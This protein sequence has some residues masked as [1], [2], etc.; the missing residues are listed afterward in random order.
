MAVLAQGGMVVVADEHDR[1]NEADLIMA[2]SA[3]TV[4]QMTFFLRHGSGIVCTPMADR[5]ADEL[6]LP[7]MVAAST[8]NHGTAFTVT[9]DHIGTGT[10]ISAADRVRTVRALADPATSPAELRRPGHIFPL[11]ARPGGVLKRAG[12]TEAAVDLLA[13]AGAGEVAVI[14]ELV[15]DDGVPMAGV[16]AREFAERHGLTFVHVDDLVRERR[17]NAGLIA[18]TGRAQLP[19]GGNRFV[20]TTYRSAADGI[21]HIALTLGDLAVAD[22]D[23]RGA[24]VRVHSECLTGDVFG[25]G[26]CDCGEQLQQAL[27]LIAAEGAGVV[28]YLRGHEG[29]G[30]G[31]GHKLQAYALQERGY[32]TLDANIALGLPVDSREYGIGAAMLADLGVHRIRLISNN[33]QK[34]G[35]LAGFDLELVDR[36]STRPVVTADNI[37]Y[38][39]TKRDRMGHSLDLGTDPTCSRPTAH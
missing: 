37:R 10:G 3:I 15:G 20:A 16:Q 25:S 17:R 6:D 2:A 23:P 36:V 31:L 38:L 30:I 7:L 22:A 35:G 9:V 28:I 5:R 4:E 19:V 27:D 11:R 8:D 39:R 29:R 26:R 24:L 1:E 32:D 21:E 34:Y 12:H 14:T 33:P 18:R 13:L